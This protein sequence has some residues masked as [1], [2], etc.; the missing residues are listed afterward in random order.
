VGE[1]KLKKNRKEKDLGEGEERTGSYDNGG[2]PT[3]TST[4]WGVDLEYREP[5]DLHTVREQGRGETKGGVGRG[6]PR[7][8]SSKTPSKR[9]GERFLVKKYKTG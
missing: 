9:N 4:I 6:G 8:V 7:G 2:R 5:E 3:G 1:N